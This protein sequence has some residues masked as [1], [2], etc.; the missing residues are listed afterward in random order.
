MIVDEAVAHMPMEQDP[1][2]AAGI[3]VPSELPYNDQKVGINTIK[4]V[5]IL[6]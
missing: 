3:T 4:I 2:E 6:C 5:L 1:F